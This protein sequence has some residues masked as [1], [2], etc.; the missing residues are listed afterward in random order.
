MHSLPRQQS[1]VREE[2][3][4]PVKRSTRSAV[5]WRGCPL[6]GLL[7][8]AREP[9]CG[10]P[11]RAT[12]VVAGSG[13]HRCCTRRS[14]PSRRHE[15]L[16]RQSRRQTGESASKSQ[17]WRP[18]RRARCACVLENASRLPRASAAGALRPELRSKRA[19]VFLWSCS[20]SPARRGAPPARGPRR[21]RIRIPA[22]AASEAAAGIAPRGGREDAGRRPL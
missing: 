7:A 10:T 15:R 9:A 19:R 1:A 13:Q 6:Q 12:A 20:A 8:C 14:R 18:V 16:E 5:A 22:R 21:A 4:G 3:D 2:R 17:L 11:W